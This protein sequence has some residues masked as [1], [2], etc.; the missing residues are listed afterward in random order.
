MPS[1]LN[2]FFV[3]LFFFFFFFLLF[4]I[5]CIYTRRVTRLFTPSRHTSRAHYYI[6]LPPQWQFHGVFFIHQIWHKADND[7][8]V[9]PR[10]DCRDGHHKCDTLQGDVCPSQ[11]LPRCSE[12]SRNPGGNPSSFMAWVRTWDE[13]SGWKQLH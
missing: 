12:P 7:I 5:Y 2:L 10:K 1:I 9:A 11:G 4:R 6:V 8:L 13:L 3:F